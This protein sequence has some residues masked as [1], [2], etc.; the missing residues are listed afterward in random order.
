MRHLLARTLAVMLA[1]PFSVSASPAHAS[2][3]V[4][5]IAREHSVPLCR[6]RAIRA[7][8]GIRARGTAGAKPRRAPT[9]ESNASTSHWCWLERT[10]PACASLDQS[11]VHAPDS[12]HR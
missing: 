12:E 5:A 11:L 6:A 1:E 4:L 10:I 9:I 7:E 8:T 3:P 2:A